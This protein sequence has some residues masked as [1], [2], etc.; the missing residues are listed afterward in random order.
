VVERLPS[1][2]DVESSNLSF[3]SI[4][5]HQ[6]G[7]SMRLYSLRSIIFAGLAI[8]ASAIAYAVPAS[9]APIE[10]GVYVLHDDAYCVPAFT[11]FVDKAIIQREAAAF[12]N[13]EHELIPGKGI[14]RLPFGLSPEYA[15]S[16]ATDGLTF[17]NLRRRC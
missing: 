2:Q 17:I 6:K 15:E 10:P 4:V 1:K 13:S 16:Y 3:R 9:A 7:K 8:V 12:L 5:N 14:D 11:A